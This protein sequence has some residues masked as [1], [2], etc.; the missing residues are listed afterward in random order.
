MGTYIIDADFTMRN[1]SL[2]ARR[3]FANVPEPLIGRN[4]AECLGTMWP[5]PFASEAIA[6]FRHTL[7]TGEPYIAKDTVEQRHDTGEVEAYD[8]RIERIALPDGRYGVVCYYYD[9]TEQKKAEE[10]MRQSQATLEAAIESM[11][12]AVFIT[13]A[14]GRL[15]LTN[16]AF[17]TFHRFSDADQS[18]ETLAEYPDLFEGYLLDGTL[19]SP[20]MWPISRSL[21]GETVTDHLHHVRRKDTGETWIGSY[22]FA[23]IR[24]CDG[25]VVGSVGVA[26]D[27]TEQRRVEVALQT[28]ATAID[29]SQ[30]GI[31]TLGSERRIRTWNQGAERLFGYTAD[32]AIGSTTDFLELQYPDQ[33][34]EEVYRQLSGAGRL[35]GRDDVAATGRIAYHDPRL[36]LAGAG[37]GGNA[38]QLHG[39]PPRHH[40]AESAPRRSCARARR[41]S[42]PCSTAPLMRSTGSTS[43]PA[44]TSTSARPSS[45]WSA[46]R[47]RRCCR[48]HS[49]RRWRGSTRTICPSWRRVMARLDETG[50]AEADYR[51]LGADGEYRWLS[52]HLRLIRDDAGRPLYRDGTIRDVTDE[53]RITEALM[54]SEARFRSLS[55]TSPIAMSVTTADGRTLYVNK[56][57]EALFGYAWG[58]PERS[59]ADDFYCD[60]GDRETMLGI[61]REQG[62]VR[63]HEVELRRGDGT[64]F[65]GSLSVSPIV[66]GGLRAILGLIIDI[67]ERKAGRGGAPG[68]RR[69]PAA[70]ERG[71]RAVC[72]RLEPR[73]AGAAPGD[74]LVLASSSSG[75]T[76]GSSARTRTSTSTSS[77]R[78][79]TGCRP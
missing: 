68:V 51:F 34:S 30:D 41:G 27:V 14:E 44:G 15:I 19:V 31:F 29:T 56:A 25:S 48:G 63:N 74:R 13:D 24:D 11:T 10:A 40:R 42:A 58:D 16:P 71:P 5:E 78:A 53:R 17:I 1:A 57:H 52:N 62:T 67:T 20:E 73:P 79:A 70:V 45:A 28:Y 49:T 9:L 55:E 35:V 61:F 43:R 69:E 75:G 2:G 3:A 72:L 54:E 36:G 4:L 60:P 18:F 76:R 39:R 37:R 46:V 23:P 50:T 38:N 26:R 65:W 22:N 21:R 66:F 12:D 59:Q 6:R 8:W 32:E 77:S 64:P 47:P 7:E 33:S